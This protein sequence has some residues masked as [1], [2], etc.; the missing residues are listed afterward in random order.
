[1]N[2]Q[3]IHTSEITENKI[4][5]VGM[6]GRFPK[7]DDI[8]EFW[9]NIVNGKE[10]ITFFTDEELRKEGIEEVFLRDKNYIKAKGLISNLDLFDADFF[11]INPKEAEVMDPQ[12]R[13]LLECA[14]EALEH[15]G[16]DAERYEGLIGV[17]AGQSM[18]SYLLYNLYPHIKRALAASNLQGG[19]GNDKDSL[20]T[21]IS[22]RLNLKGP[23]INVQSSSSTSL[24]AVA[25]AC[26][27]LLTYQCDMA[28]AGAI[29]AGPP[30]N[31]GYMYDIG[32]IMSADGHCRPFD[33]KSSGFVP[34]NGY[35]IAVLKRFEDAIRDNDNIWAV[36]SG[37]GINNDGSEKVSY[38]APSVDAQSAAVV[39]AQIV[40]GVSP[41]D[42]GYVEAHGTGTNIGD[43]IEVNALTQAFRYQTDKKNYCALGS[44]KGNIGHLDSA[45]GIAG[46]IKVA[47]A[48]RHK[49][50][51][52]SINYDTPN[53]EID[54]LNSPFYVNTSA[55]EWESCITP[56][57]AGV[58]SLGMGGTNVHIVMQENEHYCYSGNSRE[59][60][61]IPVSA[62][63]PY[64]LKQNISQLMKYLQKSELKENIS[65]IAFT[66]S[67]GRK[68]FGYRVAVVCKNHGE[69][70]EKLERQNNT[71]GEIVQCK[72]DNREVV[73]MFPGQGVQYMNMAY[74]LYVKEHVF[75]AAFDQCCEI[76]E[77]CIGV[78][79]SNLLY[80]DAGKKSR[81]LI[82]KTAV[83]QPLVFSIEY[84]MAKLLT[85]LHIKPVTMIGHSL[86]EY[87]AAVIADVF[88]LEDALRLVCKRAEL[89]SKMPEGGMLA[90]HISEEEASNYITDALSI[91][92]V[93]T[94]GL[95]VIS[96]SLED[97]GQLEDMFTKKN[98]FYSRLKVSH[99]FH[100]KHMETAAAEFR[101]YL[102]NIKLHKP[103]IPFISCVSGT[104]I[105]DQEAMDYNYWANHM[106]QTVRFKD[107]LETIMQN[108]TQILLEVGPGNTL[109]NLA[110]QSKSYTRDRVVL[111]TIRAPK[112]TGADEKVLADLLAELWSQGVQIDW[113]IYYQNEKRKRV[114]L[115][116]YSF[117]RKSYWIDSEIRASDH[118]DQ[119]VQNKIKD[120]QI[121]RYH[122][123]PDLDVEYMAPISD[124]QRMIV[125]QLQELLGIEPIGIQDNF[126]DLGGNSLIALQILT[127]I[128]EIYNV[129]LSM[130]AIFRNPTVEGLE[131]LIGISK[132]DSLNEVDKI[133][134][135]IKALTPDK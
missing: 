107:G 4:A 57:T 97:I 108:K 65:D 49:I 96:G 35:G 117:E 61:I 39:N 30:V 9:E 48:L 93:N 92:A 135:D 20:P 67:V 125:D 110:Q 94:P 111:H 134:M 120:T 29:S 11:G 54:F 60:S 44:V 42:I 5:I 80:K 31:A 131:K 13:M 105:T 81:E 113:N 36:I 79:M 47:M 58:T 104:W 51:P 99:G 89:M 133:L 106:L 1:M 40:A 98:T 22:Y 71:A 69:C 33:A 62:K 132:Q 128:G 129:R 25:V 10:C 17:F 90:V 76:V 16:Y 126:F 27:S 86:G 6:A 123:R 37:Y 14:W 73:F 77:S 15:A 53:P 127:R 70:L 101:Q 88:T 119:E 115:P 74:G 118:V 43:P 8:Y 19:I 38:T 84:S 46:L 56:R 12:H 45:A 18:S 21:T 109:S 32:G 121:K 78:N 7:S 24:T 26:Q 102:Y 82:T 116:T 75:K 52:P 112:E 95:T 85:S 87:V 50:L 103:V 3:K 23:S 64:S 130:D 124:T 2:D 91:A 63:T 100:S 55:K 34:G 28:L 114:P 66:L 72:S 68:Q 41:E 59:W 83:T 122:K